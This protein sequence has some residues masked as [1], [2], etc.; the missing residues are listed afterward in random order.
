MSSEGKV[1]VGIIGTGAIARYHAAAYKT[2]PNAEVVG[3]CDVIEGRAEAFAKDFGIKNSFLKSSDLLAMSEL[4]AVDVC[5]PPHQ[6]A[7]VAIEVAEAGKHVAVQKPMSLN[8]KES[9]AMISAARKAGVKLTQE[10][11]ELF[12][13]PVIRAYEMVRAGEIGEVNALQVT[14]IS[15]AGVPGRAPPQLRPQGAN[16]EAVRWRTDVNLS[17]GG[18]NFDDG[19]HKY[20][21]AY[22][23]LG[24]PSEV[25]SFFKLPMDMQEY[26]SVT[27]WKC[28][29]PRK[30]GALRRFKLPN[31][32]IPSSRSPL[33]T[34]IEVDGSDGIIWVNRAASG[35]LLDVVTPLVVH[36]GRYPGETTEY[37]N[38]DSEYE[39][40]FENMK[41]AWVDCILSDKKPIVTGEDGKRILQFV[42]ATYESAK[43][44]RPVNP[45]SIT[46][47]N[48]KD[49]F[50]GVRETQPASS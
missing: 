32:Y 12:L 27:V 40:G 31:F 24:N 9:D 21:M 19:W 48:W 39:R 6:H 30:Q 3:V 23:L 45:A 47:W 22:S 41:R 18:G 5:T 14:H 33:S 37:R 4:D 42:L 10:E 8:P 43:E 1:R 25:F 13:P 46:D 49:Y 36:R 29:D 16:P 38:M 35:R 2:V 7:P 11:C 15:G 44:G 34:T 50:E 20:A 17:G 26:P 28:E